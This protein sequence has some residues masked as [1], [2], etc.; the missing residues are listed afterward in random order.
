MKSAENQN[1]ESLKIIIN[2]KPAILQFSSAPNT[3]ASD[4]IKQTLIKAYVYKADW[5]AFFQWQKTL[6]TAIYIA[7]WSVVWDNKAGKSQ[8]NLENFIY[9]VSGLSHNIL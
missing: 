3:E 6:K 9:Q 5:M 4:F 2:G 7:F 1:R 8:L